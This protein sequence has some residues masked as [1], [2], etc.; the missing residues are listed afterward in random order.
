MAMQSGVPTDILE[1]RAAEQRRELH[2]AAT[3]LR[4]ALREKMDVR[5]Q[6]REHVW[7]ASGVA[8]LVA[9]GLGYAITSIFVD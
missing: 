4:D 6:A 8:A 3:E 9:L 7:P 1:Q 2:N 5:R